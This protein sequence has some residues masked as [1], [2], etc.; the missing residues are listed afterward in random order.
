MFD[1]LGLA[2]LT[3][4]TLGASDAGCHLNLREH[5]GPPIL[6][7]TGYLPVILKPNW[8]LSKT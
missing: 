3:S 7:T 8:K 5:H 6:N 2:Y 4:Y 1:E